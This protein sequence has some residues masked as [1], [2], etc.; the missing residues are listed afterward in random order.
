MRSEGYGTGVS[1]STYSRTTGT[2]PA[3]EGYRR[4]YR[5]KRSKI[6]NGDFA[7]KRKIEKSVSLRTTLHIPAIAT[8]SFLVQRIVEDCSGRTNSGFSLA[9]N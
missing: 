1:V 9:L 5:N 7:K 4:L 2:K 6:K 8:S 3:R